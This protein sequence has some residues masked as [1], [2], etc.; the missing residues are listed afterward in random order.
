MRRRKPDPN[1]WFKP[2]TPD[3][4]AYCLFIEKRFNGEREPDERRI[5]LR[6]L[7]TFVKEALR[8]PREIETRFSGRRIEPDGSCRTWQDGEVILIYQPDPPPIYEHQADLFKKTPPEKPAEPEQIYY[9][10]PSFPDGWVN[11]K[12]G[13]AVGRRSP[14]PW[15]LA[16]RP[17]LRLSPCLPPLTERR[18][19]T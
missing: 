4:R 8:F 6:S 15:P 5:Q 14:E 11:N 3:E 7:S 18:T 2:L 12:R 1:D 9:S 19:D 16:E 17:V 10:G 13:V